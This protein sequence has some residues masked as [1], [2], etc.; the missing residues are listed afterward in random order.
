MAD[1][2]RAIA[3]ARRDLEAV[4]APR[5]AAPLADRLG[6]PAWVLDLVVAALGSIAANG[7]AC[8]LIVFGAH[9]KHAPIEQRRAEDPPHAERARPEPAPATRKPARNKETEL[10]RQA[11]AFALARLKPAQAAVTDVRDVLREYRPWCD[12]T[13]VSSLELQEFAGALAN[14][15][16]VRKAGKSHV[17]MGV[18]VRAGERPEVAKLH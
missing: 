4:P 16:E 17:L 14:L 18:E 7:L 15:F 13:G 8:F 2:D 1:A 12:A 10:A 5:S 9:R 11:K 3:D 6:W